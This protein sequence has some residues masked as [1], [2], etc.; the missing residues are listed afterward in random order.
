MNPI[1]V[2]SSDGA[3]FTSEWLGDYEGISG[4]SVVGLHGDFNNISR[5]EVQMRPVIGGV[6]VE[7][8]GGNYTAVEVFDTS[9]DVTFWRLIEVPPSRMRYQVRFVLTGTASSTGLQLLLA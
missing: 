9:S 7:A 5:V 4:N 6:P 1:N 2:T 8:P 3:N